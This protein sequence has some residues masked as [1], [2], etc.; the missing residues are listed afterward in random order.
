MHEAGMKSGKINKRRYF[1][2]GSI[3]VAIAVAVLL[4]VQTEK[5]A[6]VVGKDIDAETITEFYYTYSSSAYPPAYQRYQFYAEDGAYNLYHEKREGADWPLTES[7]ITHSGSIELSEEEW[8]EF[9]NFLKGGIVEKR[10]QS[11][12]TG[13]SG[14]WLYLY[15]KGDHDQYQVFSFA[16][17]NEKN[18]FEAFCEKL[19]M[20]HEESSETV[21]SDGNQP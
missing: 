15:W 4:F 3:C 10:D 18:V 5:R 2:L 21:V 12:E 7:H 6:R 8:T 14:P 11:S 17:F 19:V 13:D 20:A 9:L 16:T 1:V